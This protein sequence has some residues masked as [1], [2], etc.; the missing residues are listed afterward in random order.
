MR[1]VGIYA[2][3]RDTLER[4]TIAPPSRLEQREK[5]EQLRA[6]ELGMSIWATV[7]DDAPLS[8]DTTADLQAARRYA[9]DLE[10][11]A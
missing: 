7:I 6:L 11:Q 8:V 9:A 5:L 3:R 2:Y 4:Y 1:H 10:S